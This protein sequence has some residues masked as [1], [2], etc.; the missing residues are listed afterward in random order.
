MSF[1]EWINEKKVTTIVHS[2]IDRWLKS[3]DGLARDLQDLKKAKD[4][5]QAKLDQIKKK[6]VPDIEKDDNKVAN[7]QKE[8]ED[9][10]KELEV[11][12]LELDKEKNEKPIILPR[13]SKTDRNIKRKVA[14]DPIE[15]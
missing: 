10:V 2:D 11:K 3:V 8:K 1:S 12:E 6:Y 13:N 4:K 7:D 9:E 5:S 15:K 14:D